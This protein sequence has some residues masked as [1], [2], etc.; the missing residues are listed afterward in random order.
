MPEAID[1]LKHFLDC[2]EGV[3][4]KTPPRHRYRSRVRAVKLPFEKQADVRLEFTRDPH[5]AEFF[6]A[7]TNSNCDRAL[8]GKVVANI[9]RLGVVIGV[10]KDRRALLRSVAGLNWSMP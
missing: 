8:D 10:V 2:T 5:K 9:E 1:D 7:P 6:I 3:A 4:G